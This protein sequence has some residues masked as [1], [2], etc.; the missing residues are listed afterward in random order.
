MRD[1]MR[2]VVLHSQSPLL[3]PAPPITTT[4]G[5]PTPRDVAHIYLEDN[6]GDVFNLLHRPPKVHLCDKDSH[7]QENKRA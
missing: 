5:N 7:P 1:M 6:F 2:V 4:V 3:Q